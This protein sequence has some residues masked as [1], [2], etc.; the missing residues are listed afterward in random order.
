MSEDIFNSRL[1]L[2][3]WKI[4]IYC[5]HIFLLCVRE[6]LLLYAKKSALLQIEKQFF[7]STTGFFLSLS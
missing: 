6:R 1:M 5:H 4:I 7:S 3:H 2:K